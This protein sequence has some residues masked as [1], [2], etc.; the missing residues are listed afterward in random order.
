MR[1]LLTPLPS[2]VRRGDPALL[3]ASLFGAGRLPGAPGSWGTLAALPAAALVQWSAG[4]AGL[5]LLAGGF[6]LCGLWAA[7]RAA[8]AFRTPDP[9]VVVI[10]EAAG[11]CLALLA[12]PLTIQGYTVA[13]LLFRLCDI[14]KPFPIRLIERRLPG[15]WGIMLDDLAAGLYA[16]ALYWGGDTAL[17]LTSMQ[18]Q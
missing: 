6:F 18:L 14:L 13:F 11:V 12:A 16:A 3:A 10:D 2:G 7:D 15:A 8:R 9:Q 5:L 17:S 4:I 1:R